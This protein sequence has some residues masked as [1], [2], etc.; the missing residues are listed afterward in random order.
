M[1]EIE[2]DVKAPSV[3]RHKVI[4]SNELA[5]SDYNEAYKALYGVASGGV[6]YRN[7]F[8]Y[9]PGNSGVSL[10]I[11]KQRINNLRWRKGE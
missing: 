9:I 5:I 7:G 1:Y 8:F 11:F 6:E 10:R 2:N 4:D 3:K